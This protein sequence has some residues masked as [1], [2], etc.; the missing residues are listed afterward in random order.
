MKTYFIL[1]C[2]N[3]K[4]ELTAAMAEAGQKIPVFYIPKEL[5]LSSDNMRAYLQ[6]MIDNLDYV[7]YILLPMGRCGNGTLGLSSKKAT[8]I[9]PRCSDCIDLLLSVDHLDVDRPKYAYFLT[10]GWLGNRTSV[11]R[12]FA[13]TIEKYGEEKGKMIIDMI[14]NH[15][16][17]FT[18]VDTGVYDLQRVAEKITP[19][20]KMAHM[21]INEL[22]G[23]FG[24]LKKMACLDFDDNFIVIPPGE[25]IREEHF[26]NKCVDK[27]S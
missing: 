11:D 24:V 10:E 20:A 13:Y 8:I 22:A 19:L 16:R 23:P 12:E 5:H 4:N 2:H 26:E 1:A 21:E 25:V 18:L 3:I 6:E 17:Y 9:L 27:I 15:Y 7:D 14:Y